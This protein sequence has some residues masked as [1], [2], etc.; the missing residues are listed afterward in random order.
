MTY[1][2]STI[3]RNEDPKVKENKKTQQLV[4]QNRK[5]EETKMQ[6]PPVKPT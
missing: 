4:N 5:T 3:D 6:G 1:T 2:N